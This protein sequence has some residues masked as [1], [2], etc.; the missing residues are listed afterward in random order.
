MKKNILTM[1]FLALLGGAFTS[2]RAG[3]DTIRAGVWRGQKYEIQDR[4]RAG[5]F[6]VTN[7]L[8]WRIRLGK[9]PAVPVNGATR[10]GGPPYST[11][12][13]GTDAYGYIPGRDTAYSNTAPAPGVPSAA[14]TMLY[15][16]P[17]TL[18]E[19][20]Y[21]TFYH[22]MQEEWPRIADSVEAASHGYFPYLIGTVYGERSK[23]FHDY[24]GI[25]N[26]RAMTLR[27]NPD[28]YVRY[29]TGNNYQSTT[30]S[31]LAGKVHMPGKIL[32]LRTPPASGSLSVDD[33][34][35]F[36]DARDVPVEVGFEIVLTPDTS[37]R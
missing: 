19:K 5:L 24:N 36:R 17:R 12:I 9:L 10:D 27:I 18:S 31:G 2:C 22:F 32:R 29:M 15:I 35:G 28:G 23:Y 33:L 1:T 7:T 21:E 14:R 30:Y 25:Q 16:S 6:A 34:R 20:Q 37:A 4:S 11:D 13:Y 8:D 26:G 3:W